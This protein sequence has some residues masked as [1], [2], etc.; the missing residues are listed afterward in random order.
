[1]DRDK[2]TV[3]FIV[4]TYNGAD[5]IEETLDSLLAQEYPHTEIIA[6]DDGSTDDTEEILNSYT[7][8]GVTVL[9]LLEN[10]GHS[11]A[12]NLAI[13]NAEGDVL[14]LMDDDI[15]IDPTWTH[16]LVEKIAELPDEVA[17]I[18]PKVIEKDTVSKDKAGYTQVVQTCGVLA[19]ADAV[20]EVGGFDER[21]FAWVNDM[22]LAANLINHGY[23]IY[24]HPDVEVRHKSDSWSG[25][26]LSPIKTFHFTKN[27]A[28][29]YWK[30]YDRQ[31]ALLHTIRHFVRTAKWSIGQDTFSSYLKGVFYSAIFFKTYFV[32]E[33]VSDSELEY[34]K[35]PYSILKQIFE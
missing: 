11:L 18:Q 15:E 26:S 28:W 4:P 22:E 32:D 24:C 14:G 1:M 3:S 9:S 12:S 16:D 23:R 29:Y 17:L 20:R 10:E 27:Y 19:K 13:A 30:H 35:S 31:S 7:D 25:G 8:E 5:T 2:P 33:H 6:V 34:P 21:Y